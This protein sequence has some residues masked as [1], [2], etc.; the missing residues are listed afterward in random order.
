MKCPPFMLALQA[1]MLAPLPTGAFLATR[2]TSPPNPRLVG[3]SRE[4]QPADAS[5]E[6][7]KVVVDAEKASREKKYGPLA[8]VLIG[9]AEIEQNQL[10]IW[11][12]LREK[13]N[14]AAAAGTRE[15][16]RNAKKLNKGSSKRKNKDSSALEALPLEGKTSGSAGNSAPASSSFGLEL[17]DGLLNKMATAFPEADAMARY[18]AEGLNSKLEDA[19]VLEKVTS[20]PSASALSAGSSDRGLGESESSDKA[21]TKSP[22]EQPPSKSQLKKQQKAQNK[23][24]KK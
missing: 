7:W 11:E 6:E 21:P 14:A 19:G 8:G 3:V 20:S 4:V 9:K 10:R 12:A 2:R 24:K 16:R 15:S 22:S 5:S 1:M 17:V 18:S 13:R 23:R